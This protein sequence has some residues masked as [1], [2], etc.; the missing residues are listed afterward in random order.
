MSQHSQQHNND[1]KGKD[2]HDNNKNDNQLSSLQNEILNILK[3]PQYKNNQIGCNVHTV[4]EKLSHY[5]M[6]QITDSIQELIEM[7]FLYS[8]IDEEHYKAA[9]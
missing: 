5:H 1:G 8:T 3:Q 9:L 2:N 7:G 6:N 4:I